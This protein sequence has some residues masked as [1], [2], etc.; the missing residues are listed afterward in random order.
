MTITSSCSAFLNHVVVCF[1]FF[2]FSSRRRHTRYWR[3]WSSDVCSS[4]LA[5]LVGVVDPQVHTLRLLDAQ[6]R[7]GGRVPLVIVEVRLLRAH[8]V[9]QVALD[10]RGVGLALRGLELRDRDGGQEPDDHNYEDR[11]SVV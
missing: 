6:V 5:L 8:Q 7:D 1:S 3:D 11:K 9:A 2:F 4:D 10:R